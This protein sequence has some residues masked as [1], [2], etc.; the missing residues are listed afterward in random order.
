MSR[1]KN[2]IPTI[3]QVS[4]AAPL[5][6]VSDIH[7]IPSDKR[8]ERTSTA[9]TGMR[10]TAVVV[11]FLARGPVF[12][13]GNARLGSHRR[14]RRLTAAGIDSC[15]FLFRPFRI[16]PGVVDVTSR[17]RVPRNA[18]R[19]S[20]LE[21]ILGARTR[22]IV[23]AREESDDGE[24]LRVLDVILILARISKGVIFVLCPFFLGR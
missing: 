20:S 23:I 10:S 15:T 22:R 1:P 19:F 12:I 9:A 5:L 8:A 3:F 13:P 6:L 11:G 4:R 7:I 18:P 17:P 21:R 16:L 24:A 14:V 2:M